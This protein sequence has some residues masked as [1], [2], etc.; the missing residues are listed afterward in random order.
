MPLRMRVDCCRQ[1]LV[2]NVLRRKWDAGGVREAL[3]VLCEDNVLYMLHMSASTHKDG[4]P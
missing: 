1:R 2:R 3:A 4:R